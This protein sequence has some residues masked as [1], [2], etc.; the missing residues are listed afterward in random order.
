VNPERFELPA[1]CACPLVTPRT[2]WIPT[3]L[4]K[5][6]RL[7]TPSGGRPSYESYES[8][9]N[10]ALAD[11]SLRE[12]LMCTVVLIGGDTMNPGFAERLERELAGALARSVW[13]PRVRSTR[14]KAVQVIDCHVNA[15]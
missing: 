7:L 14:T 8:L 13:K 2:A 11:T 9:W 15:T 10:Q 5:A 3:L 1:S 12:K 4:R 6:V